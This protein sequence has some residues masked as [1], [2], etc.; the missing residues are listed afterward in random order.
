[1]QHVSYDERMR[2]LGLFSLERRKLREN[3]INVCKYLNG[4]YKKDRARFFSVVP[5]ARNRLL[6]TKWN[7]GGSS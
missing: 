6:G 3:L 7:M 2:P 4:V 5:T 1:M